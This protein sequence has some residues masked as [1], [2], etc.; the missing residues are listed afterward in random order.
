MSSLD[1]PS[2]IC[3]ACAVNNL[4]VALWG[5][6][7]NKLFWGL[8]LPGWPGLAWVGR[9]TGW[10]GL[11]WAIRTNFIEKRWLCYFRNQLGTLSARQYRTTRCS[12]VYR[13]CL[14][15]ERCLTY[16]TKTEDLGEHGYARYDRIYKINDNY[17]RKQT[18]S[19]QNKNIYSES[20][21]D[22]RQLH[23]DWTLR[24]FPNKKNEQVQHPINVLHVKDAQMGGR[25]LNIYVRKISETRLMHRYTR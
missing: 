13:H 19:E 11:S 9:W 2:C 1:L 23:T 5:F 3:S 8:S 14:R 25:T 15:R 21:P 17:A 20:P 24:R 10:G 16:S 6:W 7:A 18:W 22:T 12:N 4:Q